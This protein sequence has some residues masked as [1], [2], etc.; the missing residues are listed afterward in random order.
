MTTVATTRSHAADA[1][2]VDAHNPWPGLASF[3]EADREFFRGRRA[4]SEALVRLLRRSRLTVLFGLSGLGKTSLLRAGVFPRIRGEDVLPVLI[5]LDHSAGSPPLVDQVLRAAAAAAAEDG[6]EGAQS[7]GGAT[8][9]EA[10]HRRGVELWSQRHKLVA[11]LLVFDQ[12]EEIFTLGRRDAPTRAASE[13]FLRELA[14]LT[15]ARPPETLKA[16]LEDDPETGRE[17]NFGHHPYKVLLSLREDFLA[18]LE[19]LR[20]PMPSVVHNRF[21]LRPMNG[22]AALSVV[23][24][25]PELI[26]A[27][28]AEQVVRFV[29]AAEPADA[30]LPLHELQVE[31]ALLSVVCRELNNRRRASGAPRITSGLLEEGRG[32]ILAGIYERSVADLPEELRELVEERLLTVS[33]YRDSEAL[34]NAL[35]LPGITREHLD[36]L[37]DRRLLRIEERGGVHR[38]ELTHDLLTGV[39]AHSRDERRH[40]Q[41]EREERRARLEAE[42]E[43][44]E[45]RRQLRRSRIMAAVFLALAVASAV[46]AAWAVRERKRA[47][48][49]AA[50]A[51]A[52]ALLI[53]AQAQA[54]PLVR[55]LLL[56]EMTGSMEPP[57]GLHTARRAVQEAVPSLVW[58]GHDGAV[59]SVAF[60]PSGNRIVTGSSDG[61]ARLWSTDGSDRDDPLVL[62][63]HRGAVTSVAFSPSG[64]HVLTGSWDGTARLWRTDGSDRDDPLVLKGHG[65]AVTSAAFSPSGDHVVTGSRDDTARL[66][67]TDGSD[68]DEPLV[69]E[70]HRDTVWSVAFSPSGE[71]VVT[72]SADTTARLW[73]TDGS[74]R[75]DP[76]VLEGHRDT[77]WSVA[78]SP[79]GDRIVTGSDDGTAR[80]WRVSWADLLDYLRSVTTECLTAEQRIRYLD[81]SA[82][83]AL[84]G[85]QECERANGR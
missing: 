10:F 76:L 84:T 26:G 66:W 82:S 2:A 71:H 50:R 62:E 6:V 55:R 36:R 79:S 80:L 31:P 67:R 45:S 21:R 25:V 83:E 5:R 65:R 61:T 48:S 46:L 14:D 68:R 19:E 72:G 32:E 24:Q 69:L 28:V 40:R 20:E 44:A 8:L 58:R 47:T 42:A 41:Q 56:A 75:D 43:A 4:E 39:V 74:D 73:R 85:Y 77:V 27:D 52:G 54:D 63:G 23:A 34:E 33:G 60:N 81:V 35:D 16:R 15:E 13:A 3:R 64:D 38:I 49:L 11:P 1:G 37:V 53:A 22:E 18:Q 30:E 29:A 59:A 70:G 7:L 51:Q 78:F 9:W 17:F 12:F 57:R